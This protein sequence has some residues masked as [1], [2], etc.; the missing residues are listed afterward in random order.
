M[1]FKHHM[2]KLPSHPPFQIDM[3]SHGCLGKNCYDDGSNNTN[4]NT[5][6]QQ[7]M[8]ITKVTVGQTLF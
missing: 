3:E 1:K 8:I 5:C 4:N 6:K 2:E 7:L